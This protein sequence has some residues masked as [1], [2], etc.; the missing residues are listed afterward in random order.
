MARI[1]G[2]R[3]DGRYASEAEMY[4]FVKEELPD[5][6]SAAFN[7]MIKDEKGNVTAEFDMLLFVP[8]MGVY[9]LEIKGAS[10]FEYREGNYYYLYQ[11]GNSNAVTAQRR[12]NELLRQRFALRE[13]LKRM[14][15][16]SPFVYEFECF[17]FLSGEGVDKDSLPPGF[18]PRHVITADNMKDHLR[19]LHKLIGCTIFDIEL[20]EGLSRENDSEDLTDEDVI[21]MFYCWDTGAN[22]DYRPSRP[23]CVF[24]SY[25]RNNSVISKEIQQILES[26]GVRVWR[27]P[28]DVPLGE[29]YLTREMQEI[30]DCDAFVILLSVPAQKSNEVKIEFEKALE[31]NKPIIPVWVEDIQDSE[32]TDYYREKLTK[33]QYRI[34]P[35]ID[36][37]VIKEIVDTVKKIKKEN[38]EKTD[39]EDKI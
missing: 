34:M 12:N 16:I 35:R 24:L 5:Y 7:P 18:D 36:Y 11:N 29:Y 10:G 4:R 1:I 27:A 28:K 37:N 23:P 33:Y 9:I 32:I 39:N 31:I 17:P 15:N 14:F 13:Y 8:H 3:P 21:K 19:F 26:L 38:D 20:K 22:E 30:V 6:I 25:N 2:E